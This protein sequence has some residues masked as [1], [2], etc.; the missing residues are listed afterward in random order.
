MNL[1]ILPWLFSGVVFTIEE[2]EIEEIKKS[3]SFVRRKVLE[4]TYWKEGGKER[5]E[6]SRERWGG[7]HTCRMKGERREEDWGMSSSGDLP[8]YLLRLHRANKD[9]VLKAVRWL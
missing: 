2:T 4:K 7:N 8:E 5:G 6:R 9:Q 3:P 1:P